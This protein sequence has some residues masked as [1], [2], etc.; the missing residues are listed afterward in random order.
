MK[1]ALWKQLWCRAC[2]GKGQ[3]QKISLSFR[4]IIWKKKTVYKQWLLYLFWLVS[5]EV[6]F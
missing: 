2:Q 6:D 4:Y 3:G 5:N 1:T